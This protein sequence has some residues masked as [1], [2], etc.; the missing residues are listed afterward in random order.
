VGLWAPIRSFYAQL[1]LAR[2]RGWGPDRF[3]FNV[4]GGR[5][6]A[7]QGQGKKRVSMYFL[8]DIFVTCEVCGGKR[9]NSETLEARYRGLSIADVL[10]LTV[11]EAGEIFAG[12]PHLREKLSFLNEIGLGYLRLGQSADTLS[13]GEAQRLRLSRELAKK[14]SATVFILDEPT[15]G[16]HLQDLPFLIRA[17]R[18]L[19]EAGNTVVVIEHQLDFIRQ[20]DW[21]IDLGPG[22][23]DRGGRVV[24][25]GPPEKIAASGSLTGRF[26]AR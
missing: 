8:P 12:L 2:L 15:T 25:E 14:A 19:V 13:G 20:A 9:F 10:E 18:R 21:V 16:L 4:P 7:C 6:E 26:L 3:S 17:L 23:G 24:A 1:P 5:C 11:K 22:G